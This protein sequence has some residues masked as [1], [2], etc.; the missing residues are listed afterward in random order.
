MILL[1]SDVVSALM[2][3]VPADVVVQWMERQ[4]RTTIGTTSIS[5]FEVRFG[6]QRL[7]LGRRRSELERAFERV[8]REIVQ[9]RIVGLD[10]TSAVLAAELAATRELGGINVGT[11]DTLIAGIVISHQATLATRNV[12]HFADLA[13]DVVNPWGPDDPGPDA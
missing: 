2:S 6:I 5:I 7:P 4:D 13:I 12:R 1:D 11:G 10:A 9:D 3:E 8:M